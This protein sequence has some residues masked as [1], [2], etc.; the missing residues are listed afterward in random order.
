MKE[1]RVSVVGFNA[2]KFR[3]DYAAYITNEESFLYDEYIFTL[4]APQSVYDEID[5]LKEELIEI[6]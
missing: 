6:L 1:F 4:S 3:Y 2:E 5:G